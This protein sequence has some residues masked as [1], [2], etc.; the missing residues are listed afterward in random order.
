MTLLCQSSVV[1]SLWFKIGGVT[2]VFL[3]KYC[4]DANFQAVQKPTQTPRRPG[5]CQCWLQWLD[6]LSRGFH[7]WALFKAISDSIGSSMWMYS[8]VDHLRAGIADESMCLSEFWESRHKTSKEKDIVV[9]WHRA[10]P[11]FENIWE[12]VFV[13]PQISDKDTNRF[14]GLPI[15]GLERL[16]KEL[17]YDD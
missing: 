3:T 16:G 15:K 12:N 5:G 4:S 8:L 2:K 9:R 14:V 1:F 17:A 10:A 11:C 6:P 7:R 13:T